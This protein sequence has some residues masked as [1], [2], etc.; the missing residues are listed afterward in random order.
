MGLAP[1]TGSTTDRAL[2]CRVECALV[3]LRCMHIVSMA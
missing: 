1:R 3:P 2:L